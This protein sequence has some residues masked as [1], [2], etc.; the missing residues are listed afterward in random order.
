MAA[1]APVMAHDGAP[2]RSAAPS[3]LGAVR[4]AAPSSRA[5]YV[6]YLIQRLQTTANHVLF[7][8]VDQQMQGHL[9]VVVSGLGI[10]AACW[11]AAPCVR[12]T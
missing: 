7:Y 2:A 10:D 4:E 8:L 1:V 5:H 11:R 6:G 3:S 9:A 12:R